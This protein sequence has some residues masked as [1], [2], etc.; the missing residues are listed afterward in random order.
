LITYVLG[1]AFDTSLR[2][3]LIK[4]NRPASMA[5]LW[6]GIGGKVEQGEAPVDAM[7]RE[8]DEEA[9][10]VTGQFNWQ[11]FATIR[12]TRSGYQ[13]VCFV[14]IMKPEALDLVRTMETEPVKIFTPAEL[15]EMGGST[16]PLLMPNLSWLIPMSLSLSS[17]EIPVLID[18]GSTAISA[19]KQLEMV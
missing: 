3:A 1:F 5:G 2:L 13:I 8:F 16:E 17:R 10:L 15:A 9:G 14:T 11:H 6:N 19:V 12:D 7:I 4:K 18:C